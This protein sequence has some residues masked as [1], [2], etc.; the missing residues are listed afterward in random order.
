MDKFRNNRLCKYFNN[1]LIQ[2][3]KYFKRNA[4]LIFIYFFN[5]HSHCYIDFMVYLQKNKLSF[6]FIFLYNYIF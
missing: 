4:K 1:R 5:F 6:F 2:L 3:S